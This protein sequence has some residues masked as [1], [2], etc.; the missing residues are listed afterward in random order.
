VHSRHVSEIAATIGALCRTHRSLGPAQSRRPREACYVISKRHTAC[1]FRYGA[2]RRRHVERASAK[3]TVSPP[4]YVFSSRSGQPLQ[5]K[6]IGRRFRALVRTVGLPSSLTLYSLRHTFASQ[7]LDQGVKPVDVARVMGYR[8][9]ITTLTFYAHAI[10]QDD[11]PYLDRLTA[12]RQAA[13]DLNGDFV[14]TKTGREI[15]NTKKRLAPRAGLEP[16][17]P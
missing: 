1:D 6:P 2:K 17:T 5:P 12:A 10:P 8:N 9:V 3:A 4:S 13:G 16:A 15:R 7:L 11:T 14:R